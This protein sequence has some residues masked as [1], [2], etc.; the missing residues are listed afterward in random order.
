MFGCR[1]RDRVLGFPGVESSF[2][3]RL[4][5][6]WLLGSLLVAGCFDRRMHDFRVFGEC[7]CKFW[8]KIFVDKD[9]GS[10]SFEHCLF[11]FGE[12]NIQFQ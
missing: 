11:V 3:S 5:G 2:R 6:L 12:K 9:L 10:L 8:I 1:S 4:F 7:L